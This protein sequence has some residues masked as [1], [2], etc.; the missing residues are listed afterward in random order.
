MTAPRILL[1]AYQCAPGQGSVSQI[2]YEWYSRLAKLVPLTLVTH[3]RNR[4]W[5]KNAVVPDSEVLYVDTEAF[6]G[7]LYR[8]ASWLFPRS[9]H[10]VFLLSSL[11]YFAFDIQSRRLLRKMQ[12]Q[13]SRWDLV[14]CVTPVSPLAVPT[15]HRLGLPTILGPWNG[16]L[17]SPKTFPEIMKQDSGWLY[18]IRHLG[19]ILAKLNQGLTHASIIFTANDATD[20]SIPGPFQSRCIR[21][22]E[23]GVDFSLFQPQPFPPPSSAANPLKVVFVGRLLPFKGVPMLIDAVQQLR[24]TT[25]VQVSIIGDGPESEHLREYAERAGLSSCIDF[26]GAKSLR[27]VSAAMGAAHVFCLPSVRESGGSVLLEAMAIGRPVISVAYGGPAELVDEEVGYAIEPVGRD[28]VVRELE[29]ALRD[30]VD[31]YDV[32]KQKGERGRLRAIQRYGWDLK[33]RTVVTYYDLLIKGR[34]DE[35]G[36]AGNASLATTA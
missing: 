23:N 20:K 4:E 35:C 15:L 16:G 22:I 5:I 6:A 25:P 30:V 10:A 13:G 29:N 26:L 32:W 18:P 3:V 12:N 21:M 27:E 31:R 11:D 9:Q 28:Y 33:V 2:G 34:Y 24:K 7:P 19:R 17:Q 14:H 1:S 36:P 8:A